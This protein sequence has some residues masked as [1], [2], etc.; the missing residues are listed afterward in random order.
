MRRS[1][2]FPGRRTGAMKNCCRASGS[3]RIPL[4]SSGGIAR[5]SMTA[6]TSMCSQCWRMPTSSRPPRRIIRFSGRPAT[7]SRCSSSPRIRA[8]HAGFS[9]RRGATNPPSFFRGRA[10]RSWSRR[11]SPPSVSRRWRG[12]SPIRTRTRRAG[13]WKWRSRRRCSNRRAVCSPPTRIGGYCSGASITGKIC[14]PGRSV[15]RRNCRAPITS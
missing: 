1:I 9:V 3:A 12:K 8:E 14:L 13:S 4:R 7:R 2:S 11:N 15:R 6:K 10:T 5:S